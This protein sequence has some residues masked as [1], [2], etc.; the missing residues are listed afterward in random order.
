MQAYTRNIVGLLHGVIA[1]T[2][3]RT[4]VKGSEDRK[5]RQQSILLLRSWQCLHK[6]LLLHARS[7]KEYD[8]RQ[9]PQVQLSTPHI[10]VFNSFSLAGLEL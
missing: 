1:S 2:Q 10:I 5:G 6:R 3:I 4:S 9:K 7:G 8:S